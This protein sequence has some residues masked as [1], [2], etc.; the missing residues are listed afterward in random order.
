MLNRKR[1]FLSFAFLIGGFSFG[2][3]SLG[4]EY[5]SQQETEAALVGAVGFRHN[6]YLREEHTWHAGAPAPKRGGG[7]SGGS[8]PGRHAPSP[9]AGPRASQTPNP[10]A[11]RRALQTP[12]PYAGRRALQTPSP[13]AGRRALQTP[14]PYAGRHALQTP[15]PYAER[16]A[17]PAPSPYAER[18]AWQAPDSSVSDRGQL[19]LQPTSF[20]PYDRY[21]GSVRSV[22]NHLEPHPASMSLACE[23]M[24][25]GRR[26]EYV[27][28]DPY[29]PNPPG[30]TATVHAGDCK[31]KALWL[32][33]GLGDTNALFVIGKTT[34]FSRTSHAWVYWHNENRWWI[35]DCTN[36]SQPIAADSIPEDRYVPYYSYGRSGA[37]RHKA[38]RLLIDPASPNSG[39]PAVADHA[40]MQREN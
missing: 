38:T 10:Y 12:S 27:S 21:M 28:G 15:S 5:G 30:V 24:Q 23:L 9:Y 22:I 18:R 8:L 11:G 40:A 25:E 33:N 16:R 7:R 31:A 20:T 14:S 6:V 32:Y 17:L 39:A 13:Y 29:T 4:D 35:L 37:Y 36:R 26:F 19:W 1:R 2:A 3:L 34:R